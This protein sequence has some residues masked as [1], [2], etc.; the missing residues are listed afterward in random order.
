ML[1]DLESPRAGEQPGMRLTAM[2][3]ARDSGNATISGKIIL[4]FETDQDRQA[5]FV[6]FLPVY[7]HNAP[8]GNVAERRANLVGW[9]CSV[10]RVGDLM[11]GILGEGTSD[12]DIELYDGKEV[13][14]LTAMY[15]S[16]R[17][18]RHQH[19]HFRS[20]QQIR[21][22][23]HTWT[24]AVHSLPSFEEKIDR[25]KPNNVAVIGTGISLFFTLFVWML[26]RGRTRALQASQA[27][28]QELAERQQAEQACAQARS[29]SGLF[30]IIPKL[31]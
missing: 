21:V 13:S 15:D 31:G 6:M 8:R 30:S 23:D 18:T 9:I 29:G 4:L 1:S 27:I 3:Q 12:V 14:D 7:K 2:Q 24:I 28:K 16:N 20:A 22:A 17:A 11:H 10:F 26:A 25:S 19:P 5:G